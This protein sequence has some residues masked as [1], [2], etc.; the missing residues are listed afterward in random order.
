LRGIITTIVPDGT[1]GQLSADDGQRYSYWSSEVRNGRAQVGQTVEFQLWEGQPVEIYILSNAAPP[2]RGPAPQ[3]PAGM[4]RPMAYAAAAPGH[5]SRASFSFADLSLPPPAYWIALFTSPFGRISRLQFWLHGV[6]PIFVVSVLFSWIPIL[7]T[8][9]S[10][11]LFWASICISF[12]RFHDHGYPGWWSLAAYLPLVLALFFTAGSIFGF[13]FGW[14][15]AEL[16]WIA[17]L[18]VCIVQVIFVYLRV[19]QP[20]RNQY[21]LDPLGPA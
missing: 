12:K 8:L 13:A 18:I 3:R 5:A 20:G 2:P 1:Y 6:L 21:G 15:L 4:T 17:T 14:L 11:A 10:L 9:V 19:G 16:L 7:G